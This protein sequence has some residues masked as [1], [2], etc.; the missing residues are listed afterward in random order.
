L[1]NEFTGTNNF[2][3]SPTVPTVSVGDDSTKV[4]TTA[5]VNTA[6]SNIIP[7][8]DDLGNAS[9]SIHMAANSIDFVTTNGTQNIINS[10]SQN[11]IGYLGEY[12]QSIIQSSAG[13]IGDSNVEIY[14][15]KIVAS[16]DISSGGVYTSYTRPAD[17]FKTEISMSM[18]GEI[19][20]IGAS[21]SGLFGPS[22][23]VDIEIKSNLNM[24]QNS[25][26]NIP[27][28]DSSSAL[29]LGGTTASSVKI[30]NTG[31]A[32]T[33][34]GTVNIGSAGLTT[35]INNMAGATGTVN[36]LSGA[37]STGTINLVMGSGAKT[38][39][40]GSEESTVNIKNLAFTVGNVNIMTGNSSSGSINL[41]TGGGVNTTKVNIGSGPTTGGIILGN[42]GNIT[43]IAGTVNIGSA[44]LTTNINNM[45][46][47]TGTV[48]IMSGAGSTGTINLGT[49]TGS[50]KV[51]IGTGS[52]GG[53][54]LGNT[55]NTTTIDGTVNIGSAGL[56]TNINN[57]VGAT[58]TVNIM[59]GAVSTGTVNIMSGAGSTG[60]INLGTGTG[61][62]KVNI[63][64]GS[65]GVIVIGNTGN[66]TSIAGTVK[67]PNLA[68]NNYTF[69]HHDVDQTVLTSTN[70]RVR[71]ITVRGGS[72][73]MLGLTYSDGFFTNSNQSGS[74]MCYIS[75]S[76]AYS[77]NAAGIRYAVIETTTGLPGSGT[78]QVDANAAT[79]MFLTGSTIL[80]LPSSAIFHIKTYQNSGS[81]LTLI[82]PNTS[83]QVLVL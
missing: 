9:G 5:F 51:N 29:T 36:I 6:I 56:T 22:T 7:Y 57:M 71:F 31:N 59:S 40:I 74:L 44:G 42:I 68:N 61:S 45:A 19:P 30:G 78:M 11:I 15:S 76:I 34:A 12:I 60:T 80:L 32:T 79:D 24:K 48:N 28:V 47:A 26:S 82:T 35:N 41:A 55:G 77:T 39:N 23:P 37:G 1:N 49:G 75:Y 13:A 25:I 67:L 58:G 17:N 2:E 64:T 65:T 54:I 18:S 81:S 73:A 21:L 20:S 69:R 50:T 66:T 46:G 10:S 72:P 3:L 43:T 16:S 8:I 52:T 63:G 33:I 70:T 62:T 14:A 83:I 38:V 27:S 4:A 53:I